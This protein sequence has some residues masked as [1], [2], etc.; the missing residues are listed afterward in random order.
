MVYFKD[1]HEKPLDIH[2][3]IDASGSIGYRNF[4]DAKQ[5]I[6]RLLQGYKIDHQHVQV[7]VT[8]FSNK[9]KEEFNFNTYHNINGVVNGIQRLQFYGGGTYTDE[10]LQYVLNH[11]FKPDRGD[12]P[13]V[14]DVL[15]I[16]TDGHESHHHNPSHEEQMLQHSHI[17][18][19]AIGIGYSISNSHLYKITGD[20][21][22]IYNST[23]TQGLH[24]ALWKELG[25]C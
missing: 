9:I 11:A 10:A 6:K 13:N 24:N 14:Q 17:T 15:I 16:M 19:Y 2:F 5:F 18:T 23:S 7:G 1:C 3:L 20:R 22:H 8:T 21:S 4:Q 25:I 12:R